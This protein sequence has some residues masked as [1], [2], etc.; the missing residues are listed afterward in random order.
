MQNE[1][2]PRID[3]V[4]SDRDRV[5]SLG[6]APDAVWKAWEPMRAGGSPER[7][8]TRPWALFTL[9]EWARRERVAA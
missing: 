9:L 6:L 8:W 4:L 2:R 7:Y 1:L 3:A 5:A